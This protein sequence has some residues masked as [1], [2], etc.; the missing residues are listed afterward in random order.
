M[1]APPHRNK[2]V[3]AFRNK[4]NG[5]DRA[6]AVRLVLEDIIK[7]TRLYGIPPKLVDIMDHT[8]LAEATVHKAAVELLADG[9]LEKREPRGRYWP[10]KDSYGKPI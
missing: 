7:H 3:P 2:M 9:Y 6:P 10:K 1:S 4:G 8:R 5:R